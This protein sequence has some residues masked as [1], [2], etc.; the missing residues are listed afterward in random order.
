[1]QLFKIN[2]DSVI[3]WDD[4]WEIS[5]NLIILKKYFFLLDSVRY[6]Q[7][8]EELELLQNFESYEVN[9][10]SLFMAIKNIL[11]YEPFWH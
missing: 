3:V 5:N 4:Y 11:T 7:I 2:S 6:S 10:S 8:R 9:K 1:M